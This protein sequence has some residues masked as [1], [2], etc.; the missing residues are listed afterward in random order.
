M[1]AVLRY[2]LTLLLL[3]LPVVVGE[4][5]EFHV[6]LEPDSTVVHY[7]E[8]FLKAPGYI[9]L[10]D[11]KFSTTSSSY[12]DDFDP[13]IADDAT[14]PDEADDVLGGEDDDNDDISP[15]APAATNATDGGYRRLVGS[16]VSQVDIAV[17][18]LPGSCANTRSGCDWTDF[19]VGAKSPEGDIRWCCSNDA[20][21]LGLCEGGPKYGK[22][23]INTTLFSG[24]GSHRLVEIDP[25]GDVVDQ[26]LKYGK[27]EESDKSGRYV[28]IFANCNDEG[29]EVKVKGA[30]VWKSDH[31]Y[32][33]GELFE[34]MYFY[35]FVT[36]V[37]L[38]LMVTFGLSMCR[39]DMKKPVK[40]SFSTLSSNSS[41]AF[42]IIVTGFPK[43]IF[44]WKSGFLEQLSWDS[45]KHFSAQ[46]LS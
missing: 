27:F 9:D 12:P 17:M 28:V 40:A 21:E 22:L 46:E 39:Y 30:T 5:R 23:I 11:L 34:F 16:G 38:A 18:H 45:W 26:K 35:S 2:S 13:S 24:A 42:T 36:A 32:L 20:V 41:R 7:S 29:R 37:Y 8:G 33:P 43:P 1:M 6:V 25:T 10:S 19:G 44:L 14:Y 31:G 15:E 4:I 3:C